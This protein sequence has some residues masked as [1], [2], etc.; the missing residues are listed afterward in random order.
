MIEPSAEPRS[1][2]GWDIVRVAI[3]GLNV[4]W[5]VVMILWLGGQTIQQGAGSRTL[6]LVIALVLSFM[7]HAAAA[8]GVIARRPW[9]GRLL[10]RVTVFQLLLLAAWL[11]IASTLWPLAFLAPGL[12][13]LFVLRHPKFGVEFESDRPGRSLS[14]GH[15]A[16]LLG[17]SFVFYLMIAEARS[18]GLEIRRHKHQSKC[19]EDHSLLQDCRQAAMIGLRLAGDFDEMKRFDDKFA[20]LCEEGNAAACRSIGYVRSDYF[21]HLISEASRAISDVVRSRSFDACMAEDGRGC[22]VAMWFGDRSRKQELLPT[23][24][25]LCRGGDRFACEMW[26][27]WKLS[28]NNPDVAEIEEIARISCEAGY[29]ALC[30]QKPE[31]A[32][33][34]CL[35]GELQQCRPLAAQSRAFAALASGGRSVGNPGLYGVRPPPGDHAQLCDDGDSLSCLFAGLILLGDFAEM[36]AEIPPLPSAAKLD[37]TIGR[38]CHEGVA[39]ACLA[40]GFRLLDRPIAEKRDFARANAWLQKGCDLGSELACREMSFEP[41]LLKHDV[42]GHRKRL[43]RS[44]MRTASP[45]DCQAFFSLLAFDIGATPWPIS[46]DIGYVHLREACGQ[47]K[48]PMACANASFLLSKF[49]VTPEYQLTALDLGRVACEQRYAEGCQTVF[50]SAERWWPRDVKALKEKICPQVPNACK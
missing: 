12:I 8:V 32:E 50:W 9:A 22:A 4:F 38:A 41:Q 33:K 25:K 19:D 3:G 31:D 35:T 6:L 14:H 43:E 37:A 45:H 21:A 27:A 10:L 44:C 26:Y 49:T 13:S 17:M 30:V 29:L 7:P 2:T 28:Q 15:V 46:D 24:E 23:A 47:T 18:V 34:R 36:P 42:D 11:A 40:Y 1:R 48:N 5:N 20:P 39:V 16:L